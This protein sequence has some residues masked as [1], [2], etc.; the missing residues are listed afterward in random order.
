MKLVDLNI[1]LYAVNSDAAHHARVRA[2]WENAL[3]GQEPIGLTWIVLLGFLRLATNPRVF[4][5]PLTTEEALARVDAWL[6][7]DNTRVVTESEEH[8]RLLQELLV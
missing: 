5:S 2:W 8:W 3:G 1:L 7:H 4:E 6:D